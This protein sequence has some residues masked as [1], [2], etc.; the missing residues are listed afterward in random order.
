VNRV[1]A[2]FQLSGA[3]LPAAGTPLLSE[4]KEIGYLTRAAYSPAFQSNI[5]M[6]YVRREHSTPGAKVEI[7]GAP[8][9]AI[10][11]R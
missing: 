8:A 4:G 11:P 6:G 2:L 7:A 10:S 3:E 5:A 1:R 9:Y